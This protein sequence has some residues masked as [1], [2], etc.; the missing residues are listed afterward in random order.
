LSESE[1]RE[2]AA[3]AG[4]IRNIFAFGSPSFKKLNRAPDDL[5]DD[6]LIEMVLREPRMLRRP[7]LVQGERVLVGGRAVSEAS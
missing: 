2:L 4:G 3:K 7:L 6:Q 5:T 1:L